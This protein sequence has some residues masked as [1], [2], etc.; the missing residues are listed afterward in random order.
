MTDAAVTTCEA[1]GTAAHAGCIRDLSAG[2]CPTQGCVRAQVLEAVGADKAGS[3]VRRSRTTW[4]HAAVAAA[5]ALPVVG[6][7]VHEW[8][9]HAALED[10]SFRYGWGGLGREKDPAELRALAGELRALPRGLVVDR[11]RALKMADNLET[12]AKLMEES[13][14]EG[15][16]RDLRDRLA[17]DLE[18]STPQPLEPARD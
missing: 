1:C 6:V 14:S 10:L 5:L 11:A 16:L 2:R 9:A 7:A 3:T 17:K 18:R 13:R 12:M 8:R 4:R 15:A